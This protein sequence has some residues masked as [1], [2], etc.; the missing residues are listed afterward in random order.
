MTKKMILYFKA[1]KTTEIETI[2][3][4][5]ECKKEIKKLCD[6]GISYEL[7]PNSNLID[8]K[9]LKLLWLNKFNMTTNIDGEIY[10]EL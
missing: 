6:L 4:L 3:E 7:R 8:T 1:N 5:K 10:F 2:E 9:V